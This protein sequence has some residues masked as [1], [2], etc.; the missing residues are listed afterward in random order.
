MSIQKR[1]AA[2]FVVAMACVALASGVALGVTDYD[3]YDYSYGY[4]SNR[5]VGVCDREADSYSAYADHQS[6][7]GTWD[8]TY[9]GY[10]GTCAGSAYFPSGIYRH[11]TSEDR[12]W[13]PDPVLPLIDAT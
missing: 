5:N 1:L 12:P 13:A 11:G 7:N 4:N 10:G 8:R 3:G 6:Y 2:L 9:D